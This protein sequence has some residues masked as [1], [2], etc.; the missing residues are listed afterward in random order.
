M[1]VLYFVFMAAYFMDSKTTCIDI[2]N[3]N[4]AATEVVVVHIQLIL[5][6]VGTI[7]IVLTRDRKKPKS[8]EN[9]IS[10]RNLASV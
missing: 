2:N 10:S 9:K 5:S 8:D 3:Y 4:E 6:V 1:I 7:L